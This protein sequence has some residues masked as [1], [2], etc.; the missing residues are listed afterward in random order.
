MPSSASVGEP[1]S[2]TTAST[3]STSIA[4]TLTLF[5][6]APG[7]GR[8][9]G[10][11]HHHRPTVDAVVD[12]QPAGLVLVDRHRGGAGV[13]E[14]LDRLA[15]DRTGDPVMAAGTL[16]HAQLGLARRRVGTAVF[17]AQV[18]VP[19]DAVDPQHR[20]VGVG[21]DHLDA[22]RPGLPDPDQLALAVDI[23]HRRAG[24]QPDH[25]HH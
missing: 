24:K 7:L 23:D 13:D 12:A 19:L 18:V 10:G 11:A 2:T 9:A 17:A 22:T 4:P 8:A 5:K 14:K 20:T 6:H 15:I 16:G 25:L 1:P 3:P 21:T